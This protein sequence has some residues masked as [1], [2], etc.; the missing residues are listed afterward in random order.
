MANELPY[1]K[2]V[3]QAWQ[4]GRIILEDYHTQG[5]FINVCGYYWIQDCSITLAMLE[6]RY[7]DAIPTLKSLIKENI[8]KHSSVDDKITI[9]FLDE[10]FD[11]LSDKRLKRS[12]SGRLGGIA[13][14]KNASSIAR[15]LPEQK[16][17]K[18]L[19][20]RKDKIREDNIMSFE[21]FWSKYP[22]KVAKPKCKKKFESLSTKD[23]ELIC[24]TL[25]SFLNYKPFPNYVHP[26]PETYLNQK[27]WEDELPTTPKVNGVKMPWSNDPQQ[28][29]K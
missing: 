2:F 13:K 6:K 16:P 24:A 14:A 19:A 26:H 28:Y 21:D 23:V 20:I 1:Y 8:I 12:E 27:R 10:Q 7:K 11:E 25:D 15:D 17:S 3:V 29:L 4:N 18:S 22:K 9:E 5:V